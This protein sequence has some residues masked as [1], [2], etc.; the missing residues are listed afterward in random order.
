M[1][2]FNASETEA[3]ATT[4][5][6]S[7]DQSHFYLTVLRVSSVPTASWRGQVR[8]AIRFATAI[9]IVR[10]ENTRCAASLMVSQSAP[11]YDT[12][13]LSSSHLQHRADASIRLNTHYFC[14]I[15]FLS[16]QTLQLLGVAA[17]YVAFG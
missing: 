2:V 12:Y 6:G 16:R 9:L 14:R 13:S 15:S 3:T 17:S 1:F 5:R 10:P 8:A 11:R 7:P 4:A